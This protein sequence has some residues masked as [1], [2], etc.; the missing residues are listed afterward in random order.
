MKQEKKM[1]T[2][3]RK[4]K[5]EKNGFLEAKEKR[6]KRKEKKEKEKVGKK[7]EWP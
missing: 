3:G 2:A 1:A 4:G 5:K 6:R 7:N